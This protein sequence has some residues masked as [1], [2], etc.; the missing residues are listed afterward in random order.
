MKKH[1]EN[2]IEKQSEG[3]LNLSEQTEL[4]E[5]LADP[6]NQEAE[7][8]FSKDW[9]NHLENEVQSQR[10]LTNV[11]HKVHHRIRLN[12]N[13]K[14]AQL[15]WW[16]TFQRVAAILILPL[17]LSFLAYFYFQNNQPIE[18]T[19]YAEIEC[20][21]GVRT[22]FQLPDGST[23]Y[24]NSGSRLKY[25]VQFSGERKVELTGEAFFDVVHNASLP[26]HVNTRNLDIKVLGTTFNVIANDDETSEEIILQT[27]KVDIATR[28]GKQLA[29]LNPNERLVL[30]LKKQSFEKKTVEASQYTSW[31]DGKLVFRNE[32]MQ[33]VARR[34]SRWYNADVLV[35]DKQ[36][37]DY[38]FHATFM[39]EPLD[40]VLKLLSLTTPLSFSEEKRINNS[41]GEFRKRKI[42][43]KINPAKIKNFR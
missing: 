3:R 13:K 5:K 16:N 9:K 30:D 21:M 2:L 43:L 12:E 11:L 6:Q 14:S 15:T 33:Q 42:I 25:P 34:L 36:L 19:S 1:L 35:D 37:D 17:T 7:E 8:I 10:D 31:K 24:L 40:E 38:A 22:K 29:L 18:N 23:G 39:D 26:F 41:D 4:S 27:G 32:N 20:P 28:A